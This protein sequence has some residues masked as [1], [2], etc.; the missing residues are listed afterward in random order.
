M[1][2]HDS[3]AH[4]DQWERKKGMKMTATTTQYTVRRYSDSQAI[5]SV[6]LTA[7]QFAK[8]ESMSQQPQGLIALG[9]MPH[10]LY[11]LDDEYQDL[12]P[13]TTIWLD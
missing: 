4:A 13:S 7:E 5:G 2:H 10:D 11:N 6:D 1:S 9:D 8:Y 12:S 3:P